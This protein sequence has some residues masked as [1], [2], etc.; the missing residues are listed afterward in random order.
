MVQW[1]TYELIQFF[2]ALFEEDS[3]QTYLSF[4]IE[5]EG[6]LLYVT[7][8]QYSSDVYLDIYRSGADEP[9]FSTK[10]EKSSGMKYVKNANG[11]ECL[12]I[13]APHRY[14]E[15]FEEEW[16]IPMG[17]R[18]RVHPQIRVEMFQPMAS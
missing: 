8:F 11:W 15:F 7:F 16:I 4:K 1:N 14:H 6:I 5:K 3:D 18:I 9:T 17:V 10:I 13:A 2:G 12:E